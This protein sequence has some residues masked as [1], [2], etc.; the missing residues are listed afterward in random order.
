MQNREVMLIGLCIFLDS[1][2]LLL[3][4]YSGSQ[5]AHA[6]KLRAFVWIWGHLGLPKTHHRCCLEVGGEG[7]TLFFPFKY[8]LSGAQTPQLAAA[9]CQGLDN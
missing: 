7:Q 4:R 8:S 1:F 5:C 9:L 6:G 3:A 2:L